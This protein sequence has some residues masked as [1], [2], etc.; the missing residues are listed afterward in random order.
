MY[1]YGEILNTTGGPNPDKLF[2]EYTQYMS[3]T[4]NT[5]G[6][7]V[8]QAFAAGGTSS[9]KGNLVFRG[10]AGNKLVYWGESHDTYSNSGRDAWSK[11]VDQKY[12]DRSYAIM[13]GNND[14]TTLYYSRPLATEAREI[15]FGAKGSTHFTAPEVAEVNHMHNHC[16]GEPN[17][18]VHNNELMAQVRKSGAVIALAGSNANQTVSFA[19]G[20]GKGNW[21]KPG[22]YT[23]KVGGGKFTVTKTTIKGK[24][25]ATGIAVLYK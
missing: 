2:K 17:Y 1:N 16:A 9:L 15:I 6:N 20:D 23:D 10:I 5:Y 13:A 21:L 22:T 11:H 8:S 18:C 7:E 12:I 25:G 14:A 3:V 24:V 4:D 19:N